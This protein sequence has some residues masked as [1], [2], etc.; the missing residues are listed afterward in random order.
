MDRQ[1][2]I[3]AGKIWQ[4]YTDNEHDNILFE[5]NKTKCREYIRIHYGM[6]QWRIGKIRLGKLIFEPTQF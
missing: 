2:L 4:V 6:R 5:G 3:E 1:K